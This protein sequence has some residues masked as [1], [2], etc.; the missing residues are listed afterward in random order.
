MDNWSSGGARAGRSPHYAH[1][2]L[3]TATIDTVLDDASSESAVDFV[4]SNEN[5]ELSID[6]KMSVVY[7]SS[8]H[9]FNS[10]D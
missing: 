2:P 6:F 10:V 9:R 4:D 1:H 8:M 7:Q 5:V 3:F